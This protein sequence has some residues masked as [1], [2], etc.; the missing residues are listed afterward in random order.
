MAKK[1]FADRIEPVTRWTQNIIYYGVCIVDDRVDLGYVGKAK[2]GI[3]DRWLASSSS[4]CKNA[5]AMLAGNAHTLNCRQFVDVM[6]AA[7]G[8]EQFL[9]LPVAQSDSAD[10]LRQLERG[11]IQETGVQ[12]PAGMNIAK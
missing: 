4:H 2:N 1:N 5:Q 7:V 6:L 9:L 8:S 3:F 11:L 10:C 12:G